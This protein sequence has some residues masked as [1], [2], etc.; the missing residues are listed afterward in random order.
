LT[1]V[2][3]RSAS[4]WIEGPWLGLIDFDGL[5]R[6]EGEVLA[7]WLFAHAEPLL[8][9]RHLLLAQ[10]LGEEVFIEL[11]PQAA[12]AMPA[13]WRDAP[14]PILLLAPAGRVRPERRREWLD[15]LSSL[16]LPLLAKGSELWGIR[17]FDAAFLVA[18]AHLA[19]FGARAAFRAAIDPG[20]RRL[21]DQQLAVAEAAVLDD[22]VGG[23]DDDDALA[24]DVDA[25]SSLHPD[26]HPLAVFSA[27]ERAH[28]RR[29]TASDRTQFAGRTAEARFSARGFPEPV[30][31]CTAEFAERASAVTPLLAGDLQRIF[32]A[33]ELLAPP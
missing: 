8:L 29:R 25:L 28:N 3:G 15:A 18:L 1:R 16:H 31:A 14:R 19:D 23:R 7:R 13:G 20:Q 26:A 21:F 17:E 33:S 4:Q 11:T 30:R 12:Q 6:D 32:E 10:P 27:V 5:S 9:V 24:L 22:L 2:R